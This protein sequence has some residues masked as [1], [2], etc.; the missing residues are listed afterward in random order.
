MKVLLGVTSS[1]AA[2]RMPNFVSQGHKSG[3][4]FRVIVTEK[5]QHFVTVQALSTMSGHRCYTEQDEWGN[6]DE[7]IHIQL[8]KWCDALMI[9]PLTA[10]TLAKIANGICDNLL[11]CAVRALGDK[12]LVIAPAMNTRMWE[13]PVTEQHLETLARI[14]TL[15]VVEPVEKRLADGDEG[16]GALAD[17]STMLETLSQIGTQ[18]TNS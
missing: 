3:H 6:I 11:T 13:N 9:A 18:I 2:Y 8:A 10:N 16:V 14:Y 1:I 5:A 7:V 4:E 12:P 15:T 17:D